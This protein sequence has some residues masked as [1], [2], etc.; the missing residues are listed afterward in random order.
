MNPEDSPSLDDQEGPLRTEGT[1]ETEEHGI[2]EPQ[3]TSDMELENDDQDEQTLATETARARAQEELRE[4]IRK[5]EESKG[6]YKRLRKQ[7]EEQRA[8]AKRQ[9]DLLNEKKRK[10]EEQEKELSNQEEHV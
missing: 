9:L 3:E 1:K 7:T 5:Y 8:S 6:D 4:Q 10:I 2:E